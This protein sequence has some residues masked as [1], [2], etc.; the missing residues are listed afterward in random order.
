MVWEAGTAMCQYSA[1]TFKDSCLIL[2]RRGWN[3]EYSFMTE[4]SAR[5]SNHEK[6][7]S[8]PKDM[9]RQGVWN[10]TCDINA[11]RHDIVVSLDERG[12]GKGRDRRSSAKRQATS[13][14]LN[15]TNTTTV[16]MATLGTL[17]RRRGSHKGFPESGDTSL[18]WAD[19]QETL[20]SYLS[21]VILV[22]AVI[23]TQW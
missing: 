4:R 8:I 9:K 18:N 22:A 1:S 17:L 11:K 10:T 16:S 19:L 6:M 13:L 7:A 5:Q 2:S 3:Q 12:V 15:Q 14:P 20:R 23:C 21:T